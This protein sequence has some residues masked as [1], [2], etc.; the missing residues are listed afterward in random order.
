MH[1]ENA[2][3]RPLQAESVDSAGKRNTC[4]VLRTGGGKTVLMVV[5]A[6]VQG[7]RCMI[8]SPLRAL[9]REQLG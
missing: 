4:T 8:V 3:F 7:K 6:L 2:E 9:I 5:P 1:G